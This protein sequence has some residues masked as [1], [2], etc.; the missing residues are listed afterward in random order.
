MTWSAVIFFVATSGNSLTVNFA[1]NHPPTATDASYYLSPGSV[2]RIPI[3]ALAPHWSDA[4]GDP[5]Q[6]A[7]VTSASANGTNNVS[8]DGAYIYYTNMNSGADTISY[9]VADVRTNP[10]AI[11]RPGDTVQTGVGLVQIL[12]PVS[13]S[14]FAPAGDR[15]VWSG[16][17]GVAGTPYYVLASSNA[18]L[19]LASWTPVITNYFDGN[20]NFQFTN[21]LSGTPQR[22]YILQLP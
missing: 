17:N 21:D 13:I 3:A 18:A 12:P 15:L 10:P 6:F 20:G 19:P 16:S 7:G 4:D 2:L 22:Y 11:Y 1:N 5:V 9:T 8:T 14:S